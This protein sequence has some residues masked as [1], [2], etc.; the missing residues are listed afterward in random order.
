MVCMS[1]LWVANTRAQAAPTVEQI[2]PAATDEQARAMFAAGNEAFVQGRYEEALALFERS[3]ALSKRPELLYN[4]GLAYDRLRR[5][6][7]AA[8]AFDLYLTTGPE[9]DR[10]KEVK[11][12]LRALRAA[13]A[14]Q[15][16]KTTSPPPAAAQPAAPTPLAAQPAAPTSAAAQPAPAPPEKLTTISTTA[17]IKGNVNAAHQKIY[18]LARCPDY[19]KTVIDERAGERWFTTE[20]EAR[21][22]GWKKAPNCPQ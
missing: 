21:T 19:D 18:H 1:L 2:A 13:L 5:D 12:R 10:A 15:A 11:N 9:P 8:A 7:Q 3:Y 4:L 16:A 6:A 17:R 14:R 22:A 20:A